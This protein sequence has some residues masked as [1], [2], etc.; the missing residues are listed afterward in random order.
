MITRNSFAELLLVIILPTTTISVSVVGG[1]TN[2]Y[3]G[4]TLYVF[5][6]PGAGSLMVPQGQSLLVDALIVAGGGYIML[7]RFLT[8]WWS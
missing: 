2:V 8:F 6:Q 7:Y 5:N 1:T 4:Y 3:T